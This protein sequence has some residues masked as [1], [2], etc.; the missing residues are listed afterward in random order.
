M[1]IQQRRAPSARRA[2]VLR[3]PH[4][5]RQGL[6]H[7]N[8]RDCV[9]KSAVNA[10]HGDPSAA[11][12]TDRL[13]AS[14]HVPRVS[15]RIA[16]RTPDGSAP[17]YS[18]ALEPMTIHFKDGGSI[19]SL[20]A[21]RERQRIDVDVGLGMSRQARSLSR[22][23]VTLLMSRAHRIRAGDSSKTKGISTLR[24]SSTSEDWDAALAILRSMNGMA[25]HCVR[26]FA[27]ALSAHAGGLA[28]GVTPRCTFQAH[29]RTSLIQERRSALCRRS[30]R[31]VGC[32]SALS[33]S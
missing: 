21:C 12:N 14:R 30:S 15:E 24:T 8:C 33:Q 25:G 5:A 32:S 27:Q 17:P 9:G 20:K 6:I 11:P 16:W 31:S 13:E 23:R 19:P 26:P 1:C 28:V 2:A 29:S 22:A 10:L 18:S 7:L 4:Q 3:R